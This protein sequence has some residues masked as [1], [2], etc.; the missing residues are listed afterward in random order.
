MMKKDEIPIWKS[1]RPWTKEQ[2]AS[3]TFQDLAKTLQTIESLPGGR[4]F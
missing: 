1:E 4:I 2:L 3:S